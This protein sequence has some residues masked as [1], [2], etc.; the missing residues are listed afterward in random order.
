[1]A[2]KRKANPGVCVHC[3][4][5]VDDRDE[6]HVFPRSWYPDTTPANIEKWTVPSCIPCNRTHGKVEE[7]LLLNLG[8]CLAPGA[9]ASA[10]VSER[11][12]RSI[13]PEHAKNPRD[14]RLRAARRQKLL[15]EI[16]IS[17]EPPDGVLP[18]FGPQ[19]GLVYDKYVS[20]RIHQDDLRILGRKIVRGMTYKLE[21]ARLLPEN[22]AI[23]I[24]HLHD[25]DF[26]D[27]LALF[28][29]GERS[30]HRGPGFV[31]DRVVHADD[32][33]KSLWFMTIL[34]RLKIWSAVNVN[35]GIEAASGSAR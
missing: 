23:E 10:G 8:I 2:R 35:D 7:R 18:N 30:I 3:C 17:D 21:S 5:E 16:T 25:Q 33:A 26:G 15:R 24:F 31:V 11:A 19:E 13:Q 1:V 32:A 27:L 29:A 28:K 4:K 22:D 6:D 34:G 12:L 9:I 14:R 20:T